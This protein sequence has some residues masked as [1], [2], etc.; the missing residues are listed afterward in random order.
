MWCI[1]ISKSKVID[2]INSVILEGI[3]VYLRSGNRQVIL[4]FVN[5]E[6][7]G[8]ESNRIN[9]GNNGENKDD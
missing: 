9:G 3:K 1:F 5:K 7:K 2:I 4:E 8:R 6:D